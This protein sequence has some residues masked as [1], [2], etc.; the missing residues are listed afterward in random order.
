MVTLSR[1]GNGITYLEESRNGGENLYQ[2]PTS[3]A[4][5]GL[6]SM[7][8]AV[9]DRNFEGD[10]NF[11]CDGLTQWRSEAAWEIRFEQ[12]K[13]VNSRI[14][15]WRNNHGSFPIPLRGR[16]WVSANSYNLLHL[17]S[18]LREPVNMLE[19]TRDHLVIDYGPVHFE[20]GNTDLW[21]PWHADAYMELHGKRYHHTHTLT[22]Y[23]LFSVDTDSKVSAPKEAQDNPQ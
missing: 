20:H 23:M 5:K 12:K 17:E 11:R 3:L 1:P 9:L 2:F 8:V 13:D 21:L 7:G 22:N 16:V 18:D 10:F 14:L 4:I 15:V 6:V 19:L